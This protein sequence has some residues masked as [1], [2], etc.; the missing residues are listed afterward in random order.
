MMRLEMLITQFPGLDIVELEGWIDL[1]WVRPEADGA[2]DTIDVARVQLI[3]DLRRDLGIEAA[4]IPMVL[5]LMDQIYDLR[6]TLKAV[7]KALDGQPPEVRA[8][9]LAAMAGAAPP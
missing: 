5:S 3:Y 7:S 2:L 1:G 4:A 6:T 8:A 9:V